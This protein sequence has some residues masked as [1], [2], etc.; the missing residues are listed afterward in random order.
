M[1]DTFCHSQSHLKPTLYVEKV[2][3]IR[4]WET[5]FGQTNIYR[6]VHDSQARPVELGQPRSSS[7]CQERP[8]PEQGK[9][10]DLEVVYSDG[11]P[12]LTNEECYC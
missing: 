1:G 5:D 4:G 11:A 12:P 8:L 7:E 3:A 6:S 10:L 2:T 9:V